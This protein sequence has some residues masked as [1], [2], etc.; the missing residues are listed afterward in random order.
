MQTRMQIHILTHAHSLTLSV[1]HPLSPVVLL[2]MVKN[3]LRL[4]HRVPESIHHGEFVWEKLGP[5]VCGLG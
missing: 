2:H 1:S 3:G 4:A 5:L